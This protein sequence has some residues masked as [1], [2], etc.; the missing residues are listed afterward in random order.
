MNQTEI[1]KV[2]HEVNRA[3]CKALGDNSQSAWEDAPKWQIDS[4]LLGVKLHTETDAG[5][6]ASHDGWMAQKI[7]EGWIYGEVKDPEA[8]TH[9]CIMPFDKLPQNQQAKDFIFCA[10]VHALKN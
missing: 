9:P 10:V 8:K 5:P 6:S 3:Y 2:C 7:A 4:A 1:A